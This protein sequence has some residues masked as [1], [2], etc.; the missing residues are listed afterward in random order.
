MPSLR[1]LW[2]LAFRPFFLLAGAAASILILLWLA[3]WTGTIP[4]PRYF[5]TPVLWHAHE[6]LFAFASLVVVGFLM[7]ATQNW[8]GKRGVHGWR[9]QLLA[10]VWLLARIMPWYVTPPSY[11]Y[12]A[13]DLA[14]LVL[15]VSFLTPYLLQSSQR[16]NVGLLA[17]LAVLALAN[18]L[19]HVEAAGLAPGMAARGQALAMGMIAV[20]I[21]VIGGRII[22]LFTR[23]A[24]KTANVRSWAPLDKVAIAL[25][26]AYALS[27]ML[28]PGRPFF[29]LIALLAAAAH[30][31]RWYLW[32][33]WATRHQPIL[34][35]ML[36]GYFWLIIGLLLRGFGVWLPIPASLGIHAITVGAIG[37]LIYGIMPRVSLGHTGRPIK[38]Q[39]AL[40]AGFVLI[41]GAVIVRVAIAGL[42]AQH[43][44]DAVI[45]SGLLWAL[46]FGIF[47][48]LFVPILT[49]PRVDGRAG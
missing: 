20:V 33:P 28:I 47:C 9:L 36:S 26:L 17:V 38:P 15:A 37:I 40:V 32:D 42:A 41:N 22:P 11:A 24:E 46:A 31:V 10:A 18:A 5:A 44:A 14:F 30:A 48:V 39:R 3:V 6:M 25:T 8:T 7:T 4:A 45:V 13:V 29:G 2:N 1:P 43:Y 19:V 12:A 35:I 16:R 34:W 23:N 27:D 49:A 21:T